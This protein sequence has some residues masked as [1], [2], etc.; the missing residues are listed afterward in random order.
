MPG[1]RFPAAAED[2]E[3]YLRLAEQGVGGFCVFGSVPDLRERIA[4]LQAVAPYP[5]LIASDLEA[6]AGQQIAWLTQHPPAASL[7]PEAAEAAGLRTAL[8]ARTVGIT[9][10]FAPVCDVVSEARNPIIQGRAFKDPAA[11]APRF[12]AG[13]RRLGLRTCAKHFPGHGATIEDSHNALPYVDAPAETWHARDLPPFRRCIEAGVDAVM[14]AHIACPGLTGSE[15]MPATLSR[16]VMTDLLRGELGFEGLVV[17]DA[18]LMDG[19][20]QGR[21]EVEAAREAIAAGCDVLCCPDDV[22]GIA[23]WLVET[24]APDSVARVAAAAV[25]LPDPLAEAAAHAVVSEGALPVGPGAHPVV[26]HDLDG[27]HEKSL[28]AAF[29][30]TAG[31][32]T[33]V[34]ARSDRAWGGAL[35]LTPAVRAD[36]AAA[37]LLVLFG[38][39]VLREGL[40]PERLVHAP[41]L[42]AFTLAAAAR[43]A[44]G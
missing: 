18:L 12:V 1:I 31:V 16:A 6:G 15:T 4:A 5:L 35:E 40:A 13:A 37:G 42:D 32:P 10:T 34:V 43:R 36:A 44:F 30:R 41:G 26:I 17:T 20:L 2:F 25:P 27:V 11:S 21:T 29:P 9:M 39:P 8:E 38:P 33:V 23:A 3:T 14:T 24:D 7:D 28:R 22:A 19:V